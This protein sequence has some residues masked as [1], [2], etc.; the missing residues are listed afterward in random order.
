MSVADGESLFPSFLLSST[1]TSVCN[2]VESPDD[3]NELV[4]FI[5]DGG[6]Y[7]SVT[8]SNLPWVAE[9][10]VERGSIE[11]NLHCLHM[12]S[13]LPLEG[14]ALQETYS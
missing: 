12:I 1:S 4:C 9:Y 11:P 13:G 6:V 5:Y 7:K 14:L 3:L 8:H 10:L 2:I